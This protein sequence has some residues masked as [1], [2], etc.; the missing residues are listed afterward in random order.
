MPLLTPGSQ[1]HK[2]F[3]S[4]MVCLKN[5]LHHYFV[6][7]QYPWRKCFIL[8]WWTICLVWNSSV[9][10][11]FF[12]RDNNRVNA[13]TCHRVTTSPVQMEPT[14]IKVFQFV[15]IIWMTNVLFYCFLLVRTQLS[16]R[17]ACL[18]NKSISIQSHLFL[19]FCV[20]VPNNLRSIHLSSSR[21]QTEESL[22]PYQYD[23]VKRST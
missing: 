22:Q 14:T 15:Q 2:N 21:T 19:S 11:G 16:K 3:C 6:L 9:V 8:M 4:L 7:T 5:Y 1:V 13:L 17:F 10:R 12:Y 20:F 23:K 18:G